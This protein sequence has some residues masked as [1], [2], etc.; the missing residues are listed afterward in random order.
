MDLLELFPGRSSHLRSLSS[1]LASR[2]RRSTT[3]SK[4]SG[5]EFWDC[6]ALCWVLLLCTSKPPS[7]NSRLWYKHRSS[8]KQRAG[9]GPQKVLSFMNF[10]TSLL[11]KPPLPATLPSWIM[12]TS[13]GV[14]KPPCPP[15]T[16]PSPNKAPS[17][18]LATSGLK[19]KPAIKTTLPQGTFA[20]DAFLPLKL[21]FRSVR[22]RL[23]AHGLRVHPE[24]LWPAQLFVPQ[25]FQQ[26]AG[27]CRS[28][29]QIHIGVAAWQGTY[30]TIEVSRQIVG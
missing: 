6:T 9:R 7:M 12:K 18:C 28:K 29:S 2:P 5:M 24:Q 22:D 27:G 21:A 19:V 25:E 20:D 23:G 14:I 3:V 16:L 8:H 15:S 17:T 11:A 30:K 4:G 26:I 13:C 10:F 1:S